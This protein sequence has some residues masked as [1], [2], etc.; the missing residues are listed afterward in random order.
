M[1]VKLLADPTGFE[2]ATSS[3]EGWHSIQTELRIQWLKAMTLV[4][5]VV[6]PFVVVRAIAPAAVV[7][8]LFRSFLSFTFL[9]V[10]Y[11]P[12]VNLRPASGTSVRT[13][14]PSSVFRRRRRPLTAN[15]LVSLRPSLSQ[16]RACGN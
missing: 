11:W 9:G 16:T 13:P 5:W 1:G 10:G 15:V 3:L 2:P 7:L 12:R 6:Q 4:G 14:T 8:W